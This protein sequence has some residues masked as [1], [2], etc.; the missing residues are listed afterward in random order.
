M[1]LAE[2]EM[3]QIDTAFRVEDASGL[4]EAGKPQDQVFSKQ[5][6]GSK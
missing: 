6:C 5:I 1:K 4:T 2:G 3:L